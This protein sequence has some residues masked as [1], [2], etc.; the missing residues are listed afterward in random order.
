MYSTFFSRLPRLP[1]DA[2]NGL[3]VTLIVVATLLP[4]TP[5]V[6][7]TLDDVR[8]RGRVNCG[9]NIGL[10]G[11]AE[12]NSLGEY[13]GFDVD[14]C[15]AVAV[16]ALNDASA[17]EYVPLSVTDRFKA[18]QDGRIDLLSRNTTW[19]LQNDALHGSFAGVSFFDGQGFMVHKKSGIRSALELDNAPICGPMH[20]SY[21]PR[22]FPRSRTGPWFDRTIRSGRMWFAGRS[23]A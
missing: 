3:A 4:P 13:R 18:L 6:A 2:V 22:S 12:A 10:A 16:A 19:T 20:T 1:A 21:C 5:A 17:V 9:V 11:F 15:R 14:L 23:T 7:A 8:D